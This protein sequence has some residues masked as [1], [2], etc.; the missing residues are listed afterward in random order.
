M[1][2]K[3]EC[4]VA[5]FLY[6]DK[7][8]LM[9]IVDDIQCLPDLG[10]D[11]IHV[12]C[13]HL[14]D[15]FGQVDAL[16]AVLCE[17][18]REKAVRFLREADRRSS[19]VARGA[20]RILLSDYTGVSAEKV[21]FQYS[22]TGKPYVM[23]SDVGFNISHSAE[24][25]LLAFGRKCNVGVDVEKIR[26]SL[27]VASIAKRYFSPEEIG[28]I[29]DAEDRNIMFF[30]LWARKEAYVKACGSTLFRELGSFS[31]PISGNELPDLGE[32]DGWFFQCL[33]IDP[34]YA[35]A[36]VSDRRFS[37]MSCY[38]FSKLELPQIG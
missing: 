8:F 17:K 10:D 33:G 35:A 34:K 30:Q 32:K 19:V 24:W 20:L 1:C 7:M 12:W 37:S 2:R 27:D 3:H 36:V 38:D 31:V 21:V 23:D 22:E 29:K 11:S 26:Y 4:A 25:V 13:V 18:E 14:P 16:H 5:C 28:L 15:M 6:I 9:E